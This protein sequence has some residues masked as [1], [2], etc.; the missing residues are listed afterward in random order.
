MSRGEP[1]ERSEHG[2][3]EAASGADSGRAGTVWADLGGSGPV[4]TGLGRFGPVWTGLGRSGPARRSGPVWADGAG[5]G[6]SGRSGP[7][8]L[9]WAVLGLGDLVRPSWVDL[10]AWAVGLVKAGPGRFGLTRPVRVSGE[11]FPLSRLSGNRPLLPLGFRCRG[12]GGARR[13]RRGGGRAGRQVEERSR[14]SGPRGG[15]GAWSSR[16]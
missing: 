12:L 15:M 14:G 8:G 9:A 10:G 7:V 1:D 2:R 6:R 3:R 13:F 5:L 11:R 4:W 16:R